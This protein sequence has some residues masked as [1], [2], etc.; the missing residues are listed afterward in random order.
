MNPAAA[1]TCMEHL[2]AA[3]EPAFQGRYFLSFGTLLGMVRDGGF[4][5]GDT[6][7]DIG[8]RIEDHDPAV[9]DL[10]VDAGFDDLGQRGSPER[11]LK[12]MVSFDGIRV[13]LDFYYPTPAGRC[14]F[15][16]LKHGA[17]RTTVPEFALEPARFL[18]LDV[19]IPAPPEA[20][21]QAIYGPAWRRPV[22]LWNYKYCQHNTVAVGGLIWRTAYPI[23]RALWHLM[24]RN[25]HLHSK[26]A[27]APVN[28]FTD[29]VFDLFHANHLAFLQHA[30]TLGD[31]LIV[32][33]ASDRM[34]ASYKRRPVIPQAQRLA[35]VRGLACVDQAVLLDGPIVAETLD[36][37]I[38]DH[39]ISV[40]VYAGDSTPELYRGAEA[41]GIFRRLPYRDG[42]ST[43]AIIDR[44]RRITKP[45]TPD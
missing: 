36:S 11:G 8:M 29:G 44:V 9:R 25:I 40:V 45:Q 24:H 35:I 3:L 19:M 15:E 22:R 33:V 41:A 13:D 10:L 34:A 16:F 27:S 5:A 32:G 38:R 17:I 2:I 20:F 6:D 14:A 43:S 18:D 12:Y 39:A 30:A 31:R 21:L 23:K 37:L 7:I 4:V 26:P 1:R 42:V 28:V